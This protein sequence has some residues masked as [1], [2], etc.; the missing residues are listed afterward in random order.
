LIAFDD[1]RE[2]STLF[3]VEL[4]RE[5]W[6]DELVFFRMMVE[7]ADLPLYLESSMLNLWMDDALELVVLPDRDLKGLKRLSEPFLAVSTMSNLPEADN[8][9]SRAEFE[10]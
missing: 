4:T 2:A 9:L 7:M 6:P 8:N 5:L 1:V 10:V 3:L